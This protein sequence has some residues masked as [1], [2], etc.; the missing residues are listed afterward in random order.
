MSLQPNLPPPHIYPKPYTLNDKVRIQL[1]GNT[2]CDY[3][4][5]HVEVFVDLKAGEKIYG[6][7][8]PTE[9]QGTLKAIRIRSRS[10]KVKLT[11]T[12]SDCYKEDSLDVHPRSIIYQNTT[13]EKDTLYEFENTYVYNERN[14]NVVQTYLSLENLGEDTDGLSV[15]LTFGY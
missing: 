13:S 4:R 15:I 10:N 5:C 14:G 2:S 7:C 8:V 12:S 9:N 3:R 1:L 11:L 6:I